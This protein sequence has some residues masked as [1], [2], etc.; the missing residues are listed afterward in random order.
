MP[1]FADSKEIVANEDVEPID[2]IYRKYLEEQTTLRPLA[3]C[4]IDIAE[5]QERNL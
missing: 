5:R 1:R 4:R 3:R 2:E